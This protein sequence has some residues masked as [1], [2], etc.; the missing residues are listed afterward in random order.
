MGDRDRR[1][2]GQALGMLAHQHRP[3]ISSLLNQ[4]ASSSSFW[5]IVMIVVERLGMAADHQRHR[6]R[7][8]L[9]AEILH[10]P[11]CDAG[12]FQ[13]SRAAP[14][15][16]SLRPARRSRQGTTT[17]VAAKRPERP[18]RPRVA[19]HR[20]HDHDRIGARKM[21]AL[22]AGQSRFQPAS[23]RSVGA[24]QFEQKRC[25]ACQCSIA[26]ASASG[27]RCSG[28][29]RPWIAIERRSMTTRSFARLQRLG[30]CRRDADA[31]TRRAVDQAEEHGLGGSAPARAP[32]SSVNSGIVHAVAGFLSTISSPPIT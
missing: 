30:A 20:Q 6:K 15:P 7:P 29:T 21:L 24:P 3:R 13:R 5:S 12:L 26:L 2:A 32:R 28:A 11:A 31:E 17:C 27:G 10:A 9:R 23:T 4:R 19:A 25:R 1:R 8:R 16:R 22:Q 18:S 14:R